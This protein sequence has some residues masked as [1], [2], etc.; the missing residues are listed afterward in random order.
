MQDFQSQGEGHSGPQTLS[1][2]NYFA[3]QVVSLLVDRNAR[4][5]MEM[6]EPLVQAMIDASISGSHHAFD[7]LLLEMRRSRVSLAALA[8][9][10]IPEAARRMGAAWHADRISWMEVSIGTGRLQSLLREIGDAW[11]ADQSTAEGQGTVLLI[12]PRNE[13]HTLGAMVA[14]GQLRRFGV[15]VCLR[16]GP[17]PED[18]RSLLE[19][20]DFDGILI[21]VGTR[22]RLPAVTEMI[23][24][25][26]SIRSHAPPILIGGPVLAT[27][28]D[29][30][31]CTGADHAFREIGIALET[32]GLKSD[33][34]YT[35]RRA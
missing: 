4:G 18:L 1:G 20:R 12:L 19:A 24:M 9:I 29:A 13:Q 33:A 2:V 6:R 27:V 23:T 17:S 21:S 16:I 31:S 5:A 22:E 11:F 25:L 32:I 15:S 7:S 8:D 30:A 26:R 14:M 34:L 28:E 10:Y 3:S 35:L